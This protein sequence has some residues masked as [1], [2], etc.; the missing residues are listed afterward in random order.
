MKKK[1]TTL[2]K[3]VQNK[4]QNK[5]RGHWIHSKEIGEKYNLEDIVFEIINYTDENYKK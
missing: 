3:I 1:M 4:T 2:K 5:N